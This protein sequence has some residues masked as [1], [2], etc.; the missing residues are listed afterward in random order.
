MYLVLPVVR[1]A[2]NFRSTQSLSDYLKDNGTV[3]IANIDTRKLTRVLR[4]KGAQNGAIVGLAAGQEVTQVIIDQAIA[5]AKAAP[6]MAGL[7]LAQK[8]TRLRLD[9]DRVETWLG[10]WRANGSQIPCGGL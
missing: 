2:S 7:D 4:T 9:A 10:L 3:A 1:K 8:G 6:S 5:A